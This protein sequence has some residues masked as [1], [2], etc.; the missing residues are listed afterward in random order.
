MTVKGKNG[1][2]AIEPIAE[3]IFRQVK[4]YH[5]EEDDR[6][7]IPGLFAYSYA[8]TQKRKDLLVKELASLDERQK[9][10]DGTWEKDQIEI[11]SQLDELNKARGENDSNL[12]RI[13][14]LE[15]KY[16]TVN[17]EDLVQ[18][19][20][21]KKVHEN[22]KEA[23]ELRY[24][25]LTGDT[26]DLREEMKKALESNVQIDRNRELMEKGKLTTQ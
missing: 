26:Q 11:Q 12:K 7:L 9:G 20:R 25:D 4:K 15:Q 17:I 5:Q 6:K 3:E 21:E 23:L 18:W 1:F 13:R 10:L 16:K 2:T 14:D 19:I 24:K 22:E 8:E